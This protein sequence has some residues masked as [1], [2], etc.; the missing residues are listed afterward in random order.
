LTEIQP[1]GPPPAHQDA[2]AAAPRHHAEQVRTVA[3]VVVALGVVFAALY[4]GRDVFVPL[5]LALVFTALLR[6][7]VR[8]ME[9]KMP[10]WVAA[11]LVVLSA[12]ALVAGAG[13]AVATP[14]QSWAREAPQELKK[15]RQRV[16]KL[17][18][19]L[20]PVTQGLNGTSAPQQPQGSAGQGEQ[21]GSGSGGPGAGA[22]A[23]KVFGITSGL[24]TSLLEVLLLVWFLLASGDMFVRK[25]LHVLPLFSEKK[26]AVEVV[27]EAE[28]VVSH[29]MLVSLLMYLVQGTIVGV[30]AWLVGLPTP[31]LWAVMTVL[32]EF[33]PYLGGALMIILLTLVGLATLDS[34]GM[35]LITPGAYLAVSTIQ[36]NLASPFLYGNRLKLNPVA[37]L[38]G[39]MVWYALWGVPGAFLAVPIVATTKVMA[40]RIPGLS[41]LGEFLGE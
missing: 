9:G 4:F 29:Y 20:D 13:V 32:L 34:V 1:E 8:W 3:M 35:A 7:L 36:N 6:P 11:T 23:G 30:T 28:S 37:V 38:V 39:V 5:G 41:A 22:V 21:G 2:H 25:L 16:A 27:H 15:A 14:I 24:L 40:D 10:T 12:I 19:V 33:I 31:A 26:R 18:H 17:I